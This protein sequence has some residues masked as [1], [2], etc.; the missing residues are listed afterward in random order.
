MAIP[1]LISERGQITLPASI[2]KKYAIDSN[3]PLI[4]EETPE[5]VLLKKASLTPLKSYSKQEI[6]TWVK[7]DQ[8][9]GRDKKWLK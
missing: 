5:G 3:T 9:L 7:E 4:V 2:R 1:I 8:P 6:Q